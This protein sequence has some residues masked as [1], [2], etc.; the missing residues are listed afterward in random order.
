MIDTAELIA[1]GK[2]VKPFGVR[3]EFRVLSLSDVPGRFDGLRQVTLVAP[4]GRVMT[5]TV[6]R[7]R[8]DRGMYILE[9][10]GISSPEDAAVFR[11]GWMKIPETHSPPL[12]DGRYYEFQLI[13]MAVSDETGRWLGTLEDILETGNHAIFVVRGNGREILVP[14]IRETVVS[15]RVDRRTMTIRSETVLMD[16]DDAM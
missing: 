3:G 11:G 10:E 2:I 13:G 14:G 8:E 9:V 5:T 1:I 4:T 16:D 12:P 6:T 7:V 15:V